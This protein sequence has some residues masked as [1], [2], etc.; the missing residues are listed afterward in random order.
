MASYCTELAEILAALYLLGALSSYSKTQ[1]NT[2]QT[3]LCN[4]AAAFSRSNTP[5]DPGI[6]HHTTTDYDIAKEIDEVKRS[7]LEMQA[8]WVK[9]H[10]DKKKAVDRLLLNA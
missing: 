4:N 1:I 7:G 10:Q 6:K 8:S 9:A 2:K 5:F 3:I